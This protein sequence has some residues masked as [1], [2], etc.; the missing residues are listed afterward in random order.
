MTV[1]GRFARTAMRHADPSQRPARRASDRVAVNGV[2]LQETERRMRFRNHAWFGM[3]AT[4]LAA[5][6]A[7]K[8]E[9]TDPGGELAVGTIVS[10]IDGSDWSTTTA[11]AIYPDG[12]LVASGVGS[13]DLT[14]GFGVTALTWSRIA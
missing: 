12:R 3:L 6:C 8:D 4:V 11:I 2:H 9:V 13:G 14:F 1:L 10:R 7:S 5:G